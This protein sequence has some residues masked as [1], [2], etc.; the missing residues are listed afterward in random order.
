MHVPSD[1]K[2][3]DDNQDIARIRDEYQARMP[4]NK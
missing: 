1:F 3:V 4:D 2:D